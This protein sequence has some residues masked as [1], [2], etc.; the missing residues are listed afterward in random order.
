AHRGMDVDAFVRTAG[1]FLAY[2]L[3]ASSV[4]LLNDL[5]D[6][7]DDRQHPRKKFRPLA[8]GALSIRA[9]LVIMPTL[10][11]TAFTLA[12]VI[13]PLF[14]GLLVVYYVTTNLYAFWLKRV[15]ILDTLILAGLY[16]LRILAGA[17]AI[18]VVPSFWLL[19]F[20]MF[21]FFSLA[22][23]K[24][25]SELVELEDAMHASASTPTAQVSSARRSGETAI[26]GRGYNPEDLTTI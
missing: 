15:P 24:R 8:S 26:P 11:V 20:S 19:A 16:T 23:A 25:H 17:A 18:P 22:L 1:A 7:K 4:Y 9:A 10:L 3:C 14:A 2:G 13:S 6:L 5:I 12:V 21:F